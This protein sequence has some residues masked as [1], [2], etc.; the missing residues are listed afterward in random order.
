MT[1]RPFKLHF[2]VTEQYFLRPPG[3]LSVTFMIRHQFQIHCSLSLVLIHL[4]IANLL[5][6]I[7]GFSTND[8]RG[9]GP[10]RTCLSS[11]TVSRRPS[12]ASIWGLHS[13]PSCGT[14]EVS[15]LTFKRKPAFDVLLIRMA[16]S[17]STSKVGLR[18][19]PLP[20]LT[21]MRKC[22][23]SLQTRTRPAIEFVSG[24]EG[25][26]PASSS[27]SSSIRSLSTCI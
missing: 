20:L 25:P 24:E 7:H 8:C 26:C 22:G 27:I 14:P 18:L 5:L 16:A 19:S 12:F 17:R 3:L 4:T 11:S 10:R 2:A 1:T 23:P 9:S 13:Y 15:I 21:S 6:S